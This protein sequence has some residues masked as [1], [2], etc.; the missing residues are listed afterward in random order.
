MDNAP[1]SE[2][3]NELRITQL[4]TIYDTIAK[5]FGPVFESPNDGVAVRNFNQALK[6]NP[7][8]SDYKLYCTGTIAR[9]NA[10]FVINGFGHIEL[11]NMD[12]EELDV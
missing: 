3:R 4:Y 11:V 12:S 2:T 7:Y 1:R 5:D 8:K 10:G 6:D 9:T